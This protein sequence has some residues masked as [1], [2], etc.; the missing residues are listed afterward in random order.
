M[1]PRYAL[2]QIYR[3]SPGQ[4]LTRRGS[5]VLDDIRRR[6]GAG[7]CHTAWQGQGRELAPEQRQENSSQGCASAVGEIKVRV[8]RVLSFYPLQPELNLTRSSG[9]DRGAVC[10]VLVCYIAPYTMA[11]I[12]VYSNHNRPRTGYLES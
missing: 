12:E 5:R 4:S 1:G 9:Q 11:E 8:I 3:H 7:L 2:P 10:E 6:T